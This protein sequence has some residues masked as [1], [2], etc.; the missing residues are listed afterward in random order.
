[1]ATAFL[2][3]S[4]W[5]TVDLTADCLWCGVCFLTGLFFGSHLPDMDVAATEGLN[6]RSCSGFLFSAASLAVICMVRLLYQVA[7]CRFDGRHRKSLHTVCGVYVATIVI[8]ILTGI[9]FEDAGWWS[10]NVFY[11]YAGIF[12]GGLLHLAGDCCTI[13]GLRPFLPVFSLHLSGGINTGNYRD[14]RPVRYAQCLVC[15]AAGVIAGQYVYQIP[16]G[17]LLFP[18]LGI[19]VLLW[20]VFY[21]I[22]QYPCYRKP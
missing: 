5:V 6:V 1:M 17:R 11:V 4:P 2:C 7:G 14:H 21:V 9:L 8:A 18:V 22:S 3:L 13:T 19:V 16:A 10:Y 12:C 20:V 15:M